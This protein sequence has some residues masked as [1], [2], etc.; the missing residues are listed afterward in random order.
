MTS[1]LFLQFVGGGGPSGKS[2]RSWGRFHSEWYRSL[3]RWERRRK[4]CRHEGWPGADGCSG[5]PQAGRRRR[6][7]GAVGNH[8][9]PPVDSASAAEA[10]VPRC[11]CWVA[12]LREKDCN[13]RQEDRS[14]AFLSPSPCSFMHFVW[15]VAQWLC[16]HYSSQP[17]RYSI[18]KS[19]NRIFENHDPSLAATQTYLPCSTFSCSLYCY[20]LSTLHQTS[21]W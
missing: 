10:F 1:Y 4:R 17:N 21:S 13:E 8:C 20:L 19:I 9:G 5:S 14:L 16:I 18:I 11:R 15:S 7:Q 12:Y 6:R 3:C 2:G